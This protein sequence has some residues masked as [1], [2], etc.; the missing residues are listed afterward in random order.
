METN[1][2]EPSPG[3]LSRLALAAV[4]AATF[5]VVHAVANRPG[6]SIAGTAAYTLEASAPAASEPCVPVQPCTIELAR[7]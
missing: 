2:R 5:T 4:L 6:A 1:E 3:L 7:N